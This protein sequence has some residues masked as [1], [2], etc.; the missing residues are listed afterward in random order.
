LPGR[1][2]IGDARVLVIERIRLQSFIIDFA[3]D[4]AELQ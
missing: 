4:Y 2:D 1:R 3:G